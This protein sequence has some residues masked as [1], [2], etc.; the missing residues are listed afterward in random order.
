MV[1]TATEIFLLCWAGLVTGLYFGERSKRKGVTKM[2]D[3]IVLSVARK[4][5][6]LSEGEDGKVHIRKAS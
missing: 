4:E 3:F 5:I 2:M 6:S 1:I